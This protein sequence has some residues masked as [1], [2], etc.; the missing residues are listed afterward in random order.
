MKNRCKGKKAE[1]REEMRNFM[2]ADTLNSLREEPA[3]KRKAENRE[4]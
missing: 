3:S 2:R 1:N 4:K